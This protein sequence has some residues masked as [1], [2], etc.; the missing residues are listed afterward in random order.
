MTEKETG[1]TEILESVKRNQEAIAA[2]LDNMASNEKRAGIVGEDLERK[3]DKI[4]L[5][6]NGNGNP[7]TGLVF[8]VEQLVL[9]A[10]HHDDKHQMEQNRKFDW[11][12]E[13]L[14]GII[15]WVLPLIL[16]GIAYLAVIRP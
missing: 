13:I 4:L 3:I 12:K 16:Y 7:N 8:K 5:I 6:L 1:N 10:K 11:S 9:W 14:S 2:V 15:K